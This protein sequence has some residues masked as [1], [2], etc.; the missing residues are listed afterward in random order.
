MRAES[1]DTYWGKMEFVTDYPVAMKRISMN[2]GSRSSLEFHVQKHEIYW[3][4]EGTLRVRLRHGRGEDSE[5]E[6][7]PD[8]CLVLHPGMMHQRIAL[9]DVV[10]MEACA[11]DDDTDTFIVEDGKKW[12]Q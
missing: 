10:L 6:L 1:K 11:F 4:L 5:I 12:A 7:G 8:D 3:V 9:T 2:K